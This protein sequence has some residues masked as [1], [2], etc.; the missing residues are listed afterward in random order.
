MVDRLDEVDKRILYYLAR[1]ARNVSAPMVAEEASVSAG[2][3]RNRINQL[4]GG[5]RH[6]QLSRTHRLRAGGRTTG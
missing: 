1:D 4:E 3:I 6:P 2:T 5:R